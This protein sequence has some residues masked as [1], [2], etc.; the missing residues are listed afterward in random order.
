MFISFRRDGDFSY[1]RLVGVGYNGFLFM[2]GFS[3]YCDNLEVIFGVY[4][5][6]FGDGVGIRL[7]F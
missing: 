4:K 1:S 3:D 7:F 5:S 2:M 6:D